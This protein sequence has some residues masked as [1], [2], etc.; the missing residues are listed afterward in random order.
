MFL[1]V[2]LGNPGSQYAFTRHN[3][4]FIGADVIAANLG[5]HNCVEKYNC[6]MTEKL[7]ENDKILIIKPLT[8]MNS[9]GSA[10]ARIVS[11]FKIQIENILVIHDDIELKPMVTKIRFGGSHKGHNGLKS[12]D[13]VI[14]R[15]YWRLR[16]GT[17]RPLD[18]TLVN[19][20]VLSNFSHDELNTLRTI[21]DYVS[22]NIL[23]FIINPIQNSNKLNWQC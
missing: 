1:I 8:Y 3:A 5:C 18:R 22:D 4:G 7:I 19:N 6:V 13:S 20:F 12:I 11:Y 15:D 21:F 2:G 16:I 9:S 14:G 10:V 17:G 23:D